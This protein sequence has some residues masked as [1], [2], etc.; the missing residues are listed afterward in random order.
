MVEVVVA[1]VD[2]VAGIAATFVLEI[3]MCMSKMVL[4]NNN[5]K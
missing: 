3:I 1:K 2:Q 4:G 5:M